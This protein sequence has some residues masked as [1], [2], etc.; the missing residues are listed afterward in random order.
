MDDRILS[1]M[2]DL[3]SDQSLDDGFTDRLMKR[4]EIQK[5][6]QQMVAERRTFKSLL[7]LIGAICF[8]IALSVV[9]YFLRNTI[10][11]SV[12]EIEEITSL[13]GAVISLGLV[14][15]VYHFRQLLVGLKDV[16]QDQVASF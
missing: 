12:K 15:V 8:I 14:F 1:I 4:V 5:L 9:L 7:K 6:G 2:K 13:M 3:K 16:R 11:L 10:A